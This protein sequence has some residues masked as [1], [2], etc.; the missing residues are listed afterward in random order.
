[1]SNKRSV[2]I[3]LGDVEKPHG[4]ITITSRDSG[5]IT[6]YDVSTSN[7]KFECT[8]NVP[9]IK[10]KNELVKKFLGKDQDPIVIIEELADEDPHLYLLE[11]VRYYI[12]FKIEKLE[13][14][15][16][17]ALNKVCGDIEEVPTEKE[18]LF[19]IRFPGYVG[20][21]TIELKIDGKSYDI[22][23]E[24]R[25]S[26]IEY[27]EQ[28]PQMISEISE[29]YSSL[30]LH[31]KSPLSYRF[32]ISRDRS[33]SYYEDFILIEHMFSEMRLKDVFYHINSHPHRKLM[34]EKSTS[35]DGSAYNIDLESIVDMTAPD[36][37][38]PYD[39]GSVL[40]KYEL[41]MT[42]NNDYV[43][44]FDTMENRLVKD[45]LLTI[46]KIFTE[47]LECN[48]EDY[49][50]DKIKAMLK[51]INIMLSKRWL[52]EV[53]RLTIIPFNSNVLNSKYGYRDIFQMY[54]MLGIGLEFR[55]DD[56]T[57]FFKGRMNK[58]SQTYEYWCYIQILKALSDLSGKRYEHG[59]KPKKEWE[60]SFGMNKG[61]EFE[62]MINDEI[63]N[64]KL[65]YNRGI[66]TKN[67]DIALS[68]S[69]PLRPDFTLIS[70]YKDCKRI[71]LFDSKYK[72]VVPD[73]NQYVDDDDLKDT[74]CMRADIYKMHTYRDAI[75]SS[76]GSYVLYPGNTSHWYTK[77]LYADSKEEDMPSVGAI[78]LAP[79]KDNYESFKRTLFDILSLIAYDEREE[80]LIDP[81]NRS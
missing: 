20:K 27:I 77:I 40:K 62:I 10:N 66:Q 60:P 36:R 56:A 44:T 32:D 52:N 50:H 59:W 7:G 80:I 38:Y 42:V 9:I 71:I 17:A 12:D 47:I 11:N 25:S 48:V 22:P 67:N 6:E 1:M 79:G 19:A 63:I 31:S 34:C 28:Y 73:T 2:K 35:Y 68:Y 18:K 51:E 57:H 3:I 8:L 69:L 64:V 43:D 16:L 4:F 26:K 53:G 23:F 30:M 45:F 75:Y 5:H 55:I 49:F 29:F 37:L 54:L 76:L 14:N 15:P 13:T 41:S 74:E 58:V 81:P 46:S 65:F 24:V 39:G 72:L 21:E 70:T 78:P 61:I 33:K